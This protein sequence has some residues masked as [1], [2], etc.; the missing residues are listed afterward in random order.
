MRGS[1]AAPGGCGGTR[2]AM[3]V[4]IVGYGNY[5]ATGNEVA[6]PIVKLAAPGVYGCPKHLSARL[7]TYCIRHFR[8]ILYALQAY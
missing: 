6:D 7:L 1:V 2:P 3:Q 4:A 8:I 5:L